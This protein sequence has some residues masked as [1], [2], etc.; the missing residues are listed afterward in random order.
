MPEGGLDGAYGGRLRAQGDP[1]WSFIYFLRCTAKV[2]T[3]E[4]IPRLDVVESFAFA[5]SIGFS[6]LPI[7]DEILEL[8]FGYLNFLLLDRCKSV[9]GVGG[10]VLAC[11]AASVSLDMRA[12][13]GDLR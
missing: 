1:F 12:R 8:L 5:W 9:S 3:C 10:S 2:R 7:Q 13:N 11:I 6:A 4:G